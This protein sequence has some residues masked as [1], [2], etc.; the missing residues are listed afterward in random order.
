M[1]EEKRALVVSHPCVVPAN[2]SVYATLADRGWK[3]DLVVPVRWR[4][5]YADGAVAASKL[6]EL[7]AGFH[8]LPVALPGRSQRHFYL[9][10][11]LPLLRQVK[12]AVAFV[13]QESYSASAF[14][15]GLVCWRLGVPFGVQ[16]AENLD[17]ELPKVGRIFRRWTLRHAAFVAARS[18]SAKRLVEHWGARGKV[19]VIP[20]AV[21]DWPLSSARRAPDTFTIGF[22]GRLVQE[23]GL[24][25]LVEAALRMSGRVRVL[26]AGNG[27]LREQLARMNG[28]Q[29][30]VQIYSDLAHE[31]MARAFMEMDVLVLPSHTTP[32]WT[33]QFGRVLVEAL[34]CG[35]PVVGSSSGEIPW[36]I[37]ATGGGL[38]F[39]ERDIGALAEALER[40]RRDPDE[41]ARLAK[42]GRA[43][44]ERL[45]SVETVG[46][47]LDEILSTTARTHAS[48]RR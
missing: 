29:V 20:H 33:E 44:V 24:V 40:L 19:E 6:P 27:E 41:R 26:L 18:P 14:Q 2:Q 9:R 15:W 1:K 36:V 35:V 38:V 30:D 39:P 45:F 7:D 12:P 34:W 48:A 13:E 43:A 37:E 28:P 25:D 46:R 47:Q 31:E 42:T 8:T 32:T 23:K 22:A 11:C 21:P 16:A 4:H 10:G 3:L 5:D 17:R